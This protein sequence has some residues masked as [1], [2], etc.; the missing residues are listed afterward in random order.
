VTTAPYLETKPCRN[1]FPHDKHVH[2]FKWYDDE[3]TLQEVKVGKYWCEGTRPL[4]GVNGPF[5]PDRMI[6]DRDWSIR[7]RRGQV[8]SFHPD[9]LDTYDQQ[10]VIFKTTVRG[11]VIYRIDLSD[12]GTGHLSSI[13][14]SEA[15][16]LIRCGIWRFLYTTVE[17]DAL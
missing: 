9:D 5:R 1:S 6:L 8:Y 16:L 12:A 15:L 2:E 10:I 14:L 13:P 4:S 17:E 11:T 3:V 7:P